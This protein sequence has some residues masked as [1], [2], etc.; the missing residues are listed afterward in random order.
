MNATELIDFVK[1]RFPDA[2]LS[3]HTYRGDATVGLSKNALLEV[4]Q[5]LK[6]DPA[7]RMN[8]LVDVTA[9]DYLTFGKRPTPAFF[10]SSG[11]TV[12]PDP[13]IPDE[14]PWPG[15]PSERF[16]VVYHFYSISLKHRFR[17]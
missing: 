15:P 13:Q 12:R 5:F 10:T 8:W 9:V 16:T 7:L 11:V 14:S 2:V 3:S 4:A 6:D 1:S 17:L